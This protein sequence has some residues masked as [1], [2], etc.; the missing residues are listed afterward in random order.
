MGIHRILPCLTEIV[1][2]KSRIDD[3]WQIDEVDVHWSVEGSKFGFE[4][5]KGALN[6]HAGS[7][8]T[9]TEILL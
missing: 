5:P 3:V 7:A 6:H 8:Q 4:S 9:E 2:D 1:Q